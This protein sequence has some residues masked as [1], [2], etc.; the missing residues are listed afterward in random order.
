ML[1]LNFVRVSDHIEPKTLAEVGFRFPILEGGPGK[2]LSQ[3][4]RKHH[5]SSDS[6][7]LEVPVKPNPPPV[8]GS[9]LETKHLTRGKAPDRPPKKLRME[10]SVSEA[11][12]SSV[13]SNSKQETFEKRA[14]Y[15]T[16]EDRYEPKKV[17]KRP[18]DGDEKKPR[19]YKEKRGDR[20]KAG[21]DLMRNFTSK[22]ISN[23]RLTIRPSHGLGLFKNGR[24]SSP[25]QR[26]GIPDLAFSE[27][28]FLQRTSTHNF[29]IKEDKI[30]SKSRDKEKRKAARAQDEISIFFRASKVPIPPRP[31]IKGGVTSSSQT[32][33]GRSGSGDQLDSDYF[34][35]QH[36]RSHSF[37]VPPMSNLDFERDHQER[38][39]GRA[40]TYISW[41]ETQISRERKT[42]RTR[43]SS[44]PESIRRSIEQTGVFRG[45]GIDLAARRAGLSPRVYERP[46]KH[47][48]TRIKG[49]IE[50]STDMPGRTEK[51]APHTRP[52][53]HKV[54]SSHDGHQPALQDGFNMSNAKND[55][56]E[57]GLMKR[58]RVVIEH[59]DPKLGWH[60]RSESGRHQHAIAITS[61]D[62]EIP[63]QSRSA[64]IDRLERAQ[65]ARVNRPSTTVPLPRPLI[66]T[67]GA[68]AQDPDGHVRTSTKQ[69]TN[70][71]SS[72]Q[73]GGQMAS[74][75][76]DHSLISDLGNQST[77]RMQHK[78]PDKSEFLTHFHFKVNEQ[79]VYEN[80]RIGEEVHDAPRLAQARV[81]GV[82]HEE[83]VPLQNGTNS[84]REH[85]PWYL[86]LPFRGFS[87]GPGVSDI[88]LQHHNARSSLQANSEPSFIHQLPRHLTPYEPSVDAEHLR[89]IEYEQ[90]DIII[91]ANAN[92]ERANFP[93]MN[94]LLYTPVDDFIDS[95]PQHS[96]DVSYGHGEAYLDAETWNLRSSH[97]GFSS[98]HYE[99]ELLGQEL[100]EEVQ[101]LAGNGQ[102]H[103][104]M[105]DYNPAEQGE[106]YEEYLLATDDQEQAFWR[107]Y[108]QY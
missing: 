9:A 67:D 23:E 24:A 52:T 27:M 54:A 73:D 34:G 91:E 19:R 68:T 104:L 62:E 75:A 66:S 43:E 15:K 20:K 80:A 31:A 1:T 21:E 108:Q 33:D 11:T 29:S 22:S 56:V 88:H 90:P 7:L 85:S 106:G 64:P 100:Y 74:S 98:E 17:K 59:F 13:V 94:G 72:S 39:S 6:S 57:E 28:D 41:S 45:T 50:K 86:G 58:E 107:P 26:R 65:L 92:T 14:R 82:H 2:E 35:Q 51:L 38:L 78:E 96:F 8:R 44:T 77:A 18:K 84:L 5:T 49:E 101:L 95:A 99:Q 60:E 30:S 3:R 89:E 76:G 42:D 105:D 81:G 97:A 47:Q 16:R 36:E 4:K 71:K 87:A 70:Q 103:L 12:T 37:K 48:Q 40:S 93:Y 102:H 10:A 69:E 79:D 32:K 46:S 53:L 61:P 63:E 55:Q 25:I 83:S